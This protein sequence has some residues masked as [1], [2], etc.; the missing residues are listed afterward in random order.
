MTNEADEPRAPIRVI[1]ADDHLVVRD[2]LQ[3][4]L[5]QAEGIEVVGTASD[6]DE[7]LHAAE[8]LDP[9]VLVLDISLPRRTGIDVTRELIG[10]RSSR[11]RIVILSMHGEEEVV[12]SAFAAGAMGYVLKDEAGGELIDAIRSVARGKVYTSPM[13]TRALVQSV[14]AMRDSGDDLPAVAPA[15]PSRPATRSRPP[16]RRARSGSGGLS[17]RETEVLKLVAGGLSTKEVASQLQISPKTADAHRQAIMR[18]LD[19]HDV[20]GLVKYALREGYIEL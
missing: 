15:A 8:A 2:G 9:D 20:A 4:L 6:G 19:I 13:A 7:A 1:L 3:A 10:E 16:R 14:R 11:A 12:S 5:I 18:K 17:P